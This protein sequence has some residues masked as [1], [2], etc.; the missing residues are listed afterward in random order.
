MKISCLLLR[1]WGCVAVSTV[2]LAAQAETVAA[3]QPALETELQARAQ[4]R[5]QIRQEIAAQRQDIAVRQQA[6]EKAC[7][8]RFAV[9]DCL[10]QARSQAR[11]QDNVL[12]AREVQINTEERQEKAAQR[13]LEIERKQAEKRVPAPVQANP[14]HG[15][16]AAAD[17]TAPRAPKTSA[18]IAAE[19]AQRDAQARERAAAQ[20]Q[21][22]QE[23][24]AQA[25]ERAAHEAER[26]V[27]AQQQ[28]QDNE[29]KAQ[30][31][32]ASKTAVN[33]ERKG[34]PLPI[35]E[36]VPKP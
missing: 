8:Q 2:A 9:E 14:R 11:E 26:R 20:S 25:A 33:G 10:R 23:K 12:R 36:G 21:R 30:E 6:A 32:R 19:Q 35:P 18:D 15:G 5:E 24:Q 16:S 4:M 34:A 31:R 13:L 22:Q 3:A 28:M 17:G 1:T 29:R 27:K 7:W